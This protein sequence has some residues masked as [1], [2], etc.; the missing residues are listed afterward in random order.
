[1]PMLASGTMLVTGLAILRDTLRRSPE[2]S[3]EIKGLLAYLF[4]LRVVLFTLLVAAYVGSI[5]IVGFL[6]ASGG[7]LFV[8]IWTLWTKGPGWSLAIS[9]LSIGLIYLL[10]RVVFQ[11]VLPMGSLWR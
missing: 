5:P 8:A 9:L 4:P 1:M 10:F 2:E 3:R 7:F 6:P 11:V